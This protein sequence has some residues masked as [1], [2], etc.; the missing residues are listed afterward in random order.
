MTTRRPR[1]AGWHDARIH[2]CMGSE[3]YLHRFQESGEHI[4]VVEDDEDTLELLRRALERDGYVVEAAHG[5][6]EA[7]RKTEQRAFDLILSDLSMASGDGFTLVRELRLAGLYEG[8]V[9]LMSAESGVERRV[10][11]LDLGADDFLPKPIVLDELH[12]RVRAHLRRAKRYAALRRDSLHDALTGVLNRQG[13]AELFRSFSSLLSRRSG[14]LSLLLVDVDDFKRVNDS[15]GHVVGDRALWQVARTLASSI[16]ASDSIGRWGG[17]EFVILAPEAD[18]DTAE[19]LR[20]RMCTLCPIALAGAHGE[21][22]LTLSIGAAT[23]RDGESLEALVGRADEAMYSA[24]KSRKGG[25][26]H[27]RFTV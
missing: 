25:R 19:S 12:A 26:S 3:T 2:G 10:R 17:D 21:L 15:H 27:S 9:I 13:F 5:G 11:G 8:P 24:K 1:H 6:R 14:T 16:R 18:Q 23:Y 20:Q 4:L 7:I 22:S